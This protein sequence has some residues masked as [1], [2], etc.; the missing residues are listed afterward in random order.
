MH[1]LISCPI[2]RDRNRSVS[3][4]CF[5][6][7]S[8]INIQS[9]LTLCLCATASRWRAAYRDRKREGDRVCGRNDGDRGSQNGSH[10]TDNNNGNGGGGSTVRNEVSGTGSN[11]GGTMCPTMWERIDSVVGQRVRT[12]GLEERVGGVGNGVVRAGVVRRWK[13]EMNRV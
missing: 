13:V 11:N 8:L 3:I 1:R 9:L 5:V 7:W 10:N 4:G 12:S 6:A 2:G